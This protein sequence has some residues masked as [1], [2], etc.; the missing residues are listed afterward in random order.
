MKPKLT[1]NI[2]FTYFMGN[3]TSLQKKLI[4]EWLSDSENLE[5]Y[6]EWL[7][8][9]ERTYPQFIPDVDQAALLQ[10]SRIQQ[11]DHDWQEPGVPPIYTPGK[12]G[13]L[14]YAALGRIAVF[15]VILGVMAF[16]IKDSLLYREYKTGFG[17][18]RTLNLNDNSLVVLN[19]NSSLRVPVFGFATRHRN[20]YLEGEAEFV[21]N[22]MKDGLPFTVHTADDSKVTVL[23]TEFVVYARGKGMHV[24]LNK[25]KVRLTAA[26]NPNALLMHPGDKASVAADGN[27]RLEKLSAAR[28]KEQSAWK[29]HR[30][31]FDHTS[32]AEISRKINEI[33]GLQIS[34]TDSLLTKRELTG[35]FKAQN[36]DELLAVLSE[37]LDIDIV[38]QD[39]RLVF[40]PKL[41]TP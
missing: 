28:M 29:E 36:A 38:H 30:F 12:T 9:W 41:H 22:R 18:L 40:S 31:V 39:H 13:W 15:L 7:E 4:E 14:R 37:M 1:K 32:L 3:A 25:G 21:V 6:Y 20:V 5:L 24:A 16:L 19:A 33:F 23:G 35:T 34:I 10:L 11:E 17:E 27:I 26:K 8:E 2:L